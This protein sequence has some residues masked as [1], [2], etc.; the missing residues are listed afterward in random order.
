V[1]SEEGAQ[2]EVFPVDGKAYYTFGREPTAVDVVLSGAG[3]SRT[4]AALV[5]HEDGKTYLI[6]LQSV[7]SYTEAGSCI[8]P[9]LRVRHLIFGCCADARHVCKRQKAASQ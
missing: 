7:Q 9:P 1:Y 6:D 3:A 2:Q 4:H 8:F 5:H